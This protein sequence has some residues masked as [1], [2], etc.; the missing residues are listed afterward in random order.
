MLAA[1]APGGAL[2]GAYRGGYPMNSRCRGVARGEGGRVV[3]G[4]GGGGP[5]LAAGAPGGALWGAYRG[6]YP[7]NSRCRGR[8][9]ERGLRQARGPSG[10]GPRS[11]FGPDSGTLGGWYPYR[12]EYREVLGSEG[13]DLRMF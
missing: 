8:G 7:M 3:A 13:G 11:R 6:G 10:G 2:W 12:V 9:G 1:G 5:T 4:D